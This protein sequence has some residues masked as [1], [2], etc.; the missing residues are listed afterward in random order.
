MKR[1]LILA[2]LVSILA[3]CTV[4]PTGQPRLLVDTI[5]DQFAEDA[6]AK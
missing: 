4:G 1:L 3:G 2:V 6:T 5:V